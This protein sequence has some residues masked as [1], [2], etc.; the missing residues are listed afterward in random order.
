MT[1]I[2][3]PA[4]ELD[5]I[6]SITHQDLVSAIT[7]KPAHAITFQVTE[8]CCMNCSYCYQHNKTSKKM[9]FDIAKKFIDDLLS[10]KY[11][12]MT[13]ENTGG[14]TIEFI[15]GE[16]L[17][18]IDLID[19][20]WT[21]L[22]DQ[23]ILLNHPWAPYVKMSICSNGLLYSNPK[24]KEFLIKY[25]KWMSF[26]ISIDGN[27]ELHD[28]CRKDLKGNGTYDIAIDAVKDYYN[29]TGIMMG[30]KS[31][32]SPDNI[33]YL[34]KS[35][36]NLIDLGYRDIH[37]NCIFEKGWT[38]EHAKILYKEL[39]Q[40]ADFI[41]DNKLNNKIYYSFLDKTYGM[42]VSE[43]E[44]N[45]WCGGVGQENF[46]IDPDG[47]L[48]PCV[49]YMNSSLNNRQEPLSFGNIK[50]GYN[51]TEKDHHVIEL[52]SNIT[53]RSQSTDECFYCPVGSGCSWCSAY[54]YEEFGTPN[55]RATYICIMHKATSLANAYYYNKL[56]KT[57]NLSYRKPIYL[58]KDEAINII[59]EN[60]YNELIKGSEI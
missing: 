42:P 57:Y 17:L 10:D 36:L 33:K 29:T 39:K 40:I 1:P 49:R 16:P 24:V 34:Y 58:P 13:K 14:L 56:Y 22:M 26:S 35:F 44:N 27:K 23:L 11:Y 60:E 45:N 54:N 41:I 30:T 52:L 20:I 51:I 2:I 21:Y 25:K 7:G 50:D 46:A 48:Y 55:K 4:T 19:K 6:T 3:L 59:G 47:K 31:T 15:G 37:V 43:S 38:I 28:A 53:R 8:D 18:E 9:S 12:L 32:I 5:F